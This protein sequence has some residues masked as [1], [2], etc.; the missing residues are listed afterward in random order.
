ME[1]IELKRASAVDRVIACAID[2]VIACLCLIIPVVGPL[3]AFSYLIFR[4]SLPFLKGQSLGK[5]L[6]KLRVISEETGKDLNE[7]YSISLIRNIPAIIPVFNL[8]DLALL[9]MS[10]DGKRYG[11][12]WGKTKVIKE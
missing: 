12:K 4:D 6:M 7:E 3:V 1:T 11:D 8:L 9:F 5:Q 10:D 2:I